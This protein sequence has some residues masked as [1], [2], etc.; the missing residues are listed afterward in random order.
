MAFYPCSNHHAPYRGP[1]CAAYPAIV[2]GQSS[3]RRHLR[4]CQPCFGDYLEGIGQRLTE[5]DFG[6]T[7]VEDHSKE[8]RACAWCGAQRDDRQVFVTAYPKGEPERAFFGSVC[9][10]C[11]PKA[12]A[13]VLLS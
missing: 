8:N 12:I 6:S 9:V 2:E 10:E 13:E 1:S 3:N 7:A 5:V 11:E 4:M